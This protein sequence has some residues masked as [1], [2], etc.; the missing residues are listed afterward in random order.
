MTRTSLF[1]K[2]RTNFL[3]LKTKMLDKLLGSSNWTI[4]FV[5]EH[6][7]SK[8][9]TIV[10]IIYCRKMH[11]LHTTLQINAG[12]QRLAVAGVQAGHCLALV[13]LVSS[14][15]HPGAG[16]RWWLPPSV[17]PGPRRRHHCIEW[18][19]CLYP[20]LWY[21]WVHGVKSPVPYSQA[22]DTVCPGTYYQNRILCPSLSLC[23]GPAGGK[24][25]PWKNHVKKWFKKI[26]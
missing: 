14:P 4:V 16:C 1:S 9:H 15:C 24:T 7:G 6:F 10:L 11:K 25:D 17:P 22:V 3:V 8:N 13:R 5:K 21:R 19:S 26:L 18:V 2:C 23:V 20:V 12:H